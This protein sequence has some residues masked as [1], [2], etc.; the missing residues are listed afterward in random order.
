[1]TERAGQASNL[2]AVERPKSP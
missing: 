2:V 1:L